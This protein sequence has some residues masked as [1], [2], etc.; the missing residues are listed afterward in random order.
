ML[1]EDGTIRQVELAA[2]AGLHRA[3]VA[4]KLSQLKEAGLIERVGSD[5]AGYWL[6]HGLAHETVE[7]KD[8]DA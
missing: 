1:T 2:R 6:V 4:R 3:T 5:R 8:E 7:G